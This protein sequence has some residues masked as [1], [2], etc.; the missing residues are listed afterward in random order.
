MNQ[1]WRDLAVAIW[2]KYFRRL[3]YEQGTCILSTRRRSTL[4]CSGQG[5]FQY[6]RYRFGLGTPE[7]G[8]SMNTVLRSPVRE[9]LGIQVLK[10]P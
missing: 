1:L 3:S 8:I 4:I 2:S 5:L 7:K 10:G 6:F 9:D